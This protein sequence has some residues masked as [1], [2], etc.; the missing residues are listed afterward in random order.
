M[1]LVR[2]I[3]ITAVGIAAALAIWTAPAVATTVYADPPTHVPT[4]NPWG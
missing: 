3:L 4:D 2:S 1:S